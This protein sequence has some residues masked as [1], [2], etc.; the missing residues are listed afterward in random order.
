M[1]MRR[2]NFHATVAL[3]FGDLPVLVCFSPGMTF[4]MKPDEARQ[5]ALDIADALDQLH[6]GGGAGC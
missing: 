3:Q 5:L 6:N 4:E 2:R 1:R